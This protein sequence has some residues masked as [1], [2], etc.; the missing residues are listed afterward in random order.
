MAFATICCAN[1]DW[2][3]FA[4]GGDCCTACAA[5]NVLHA[6]IGVISFVEASLVRGAV[7]GFVSETAFVFK[8][9]NI[10]RS[11][12]SS[13]GFM[14]SEL[15]LGTGRAVIMSS[16]LMISVSARGKLAI[17]LA[18]VPQWQNCL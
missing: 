14:T 18:M 17:S 4:A 7:E 16:D 3:S 1:E 15:D 5:E 13:E 10:M 8:G 12:K 11:K 6:P 2:D 9:S